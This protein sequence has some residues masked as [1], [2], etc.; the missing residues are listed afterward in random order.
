MIFVKAADAVASL[1][2]QQDKP[3]AGVNGPTVVGTC[4]L[5]TLE[6]LYANF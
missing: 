4:C 6:C 1:W 5:A 3:A 2:N